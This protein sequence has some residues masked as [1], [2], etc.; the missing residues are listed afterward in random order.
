MIFAVQQSDSVILYTQ[1][2]HSHIPES[3]IKATYIEMIKPE[4][5]TYLRNMREMK[6]T[7]HDKQND[8]YFS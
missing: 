2:A 4:F 5:H 6:E 3:F 7:T 8:S 1:L